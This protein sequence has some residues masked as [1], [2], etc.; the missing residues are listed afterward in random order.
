MEKLVENVLIAQD[1]YSL[2][3]IC[4]PTFLTNQVSSKF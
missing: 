3:I 4:T 2:K 1:F